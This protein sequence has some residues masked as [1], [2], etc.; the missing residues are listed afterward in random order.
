MMQAKL[1]KKEMNIVE[2]SFIKLQYKQLGYISK[3][4]FNILVKKKH[5]LIKGTSLKTCTYYLTSQQHKDIFH[6]SP[7]Y[8]EDSI[9]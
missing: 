9:F 3:Q 5:L 1:Y 8:M 6:K 2:N 4:G 7:P